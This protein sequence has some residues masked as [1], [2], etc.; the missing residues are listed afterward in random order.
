MG[1]VC[2]WF[3]AEVIAGAI[4]PA[5]ASWVEGAGGGGCT[6]S[7]SN[8]TCPIS[9]MKKILLATWIINLGKIG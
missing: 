9:V 7:L 3:A 4:T 5:M 2:L 1:T 8:D 6:T